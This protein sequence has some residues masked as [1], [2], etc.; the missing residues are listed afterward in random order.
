MNERTHERVTISRIYCNQATTEAFK[1]VWEEF[2]AAIENATG[3]KLLMLPFHGE[4]KLCAIICD[5]E[6]AQAKGLGLV[7]ARL[8]DPRISGINETDPDILLTYI[9]KVCVQ[10]YDR[11]LL[12]LAAGGRSLVDY[13]KTFR[14]L[15]HP[16]DFQAFAKFC[17]ESPLVA[18]RDWYN[19][20]TMYPWYLPALNRNLSRMTAEAWMSTPDST[21]LVE[22]AHPAA[23]QATGTGLGLLDAIKSARKYDFEVAASIAAAEQSMILRNTLNDTA[24]RL[25]RR[26]G[27]AATRANKDEARREIIN[28]I[29]ETNKALEESTQISRAEVEKRKEIQEKQKGLRTLYKSIPSSQPI[30]PRSSQRSVRP[31][32]QIPIPHAQNCTPIPQPTYPSPHPPSLWPSIVPTAYPFTDFHHHAYT[33]AAN[34]SEDV[35]PNVPEFVQGSSRGI[36][37]NGG[38]GG[39]GRGAGVNPYMPVN[40]GNGYHYN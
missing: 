2:F 28:R 25:S 5:A 31:H 21:N 36:G 23:N 40:Y 19:N 32:L 30:V 1:R 18:V 22:S 6:P 16:G 14:S 38:D 13:L 3:Q 24:S 26:V 7:L 9:F 27:R 4:G 37:G 33:V 34:S 20:K 10:H 11:G 8:N 17:H 29:E 39:D 12:K 35:V 15:E